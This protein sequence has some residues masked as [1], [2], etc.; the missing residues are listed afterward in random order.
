MTYYSN[1]TPEDQ[2]TADAAIDTI[3]GLLGLDHRHTDA[4][5]DALDEL[6]DLAE[7]IEAN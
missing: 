4:L 5:V 2:I 1:L 3:L 7:A 6:V